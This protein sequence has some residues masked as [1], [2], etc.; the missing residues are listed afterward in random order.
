M[1]E[2][3]PALFASFFVLISL[4]SLLLHDAIPG[5]KRPAWAQTQESLSELGLRFELRR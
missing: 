2:I 5:T 4:I 3:S 1:R